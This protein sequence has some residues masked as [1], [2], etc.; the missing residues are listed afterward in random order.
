[1]EEATSAEDED[2][3]LGKKL[4]KNTGNSYVRIALQLMRE[5]S[6]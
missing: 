4:N 2:T 5:W 3:D 1:M 6:M